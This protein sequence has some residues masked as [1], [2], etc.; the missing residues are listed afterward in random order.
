[1]NSKDKG[2][3]DQ[4]MKIL[5]AQSQ[6]EGVAYITGE[7]LAG[8][9]V[10]IQKIAS[11]GQGDV[12][13]AYN[14]SIG[15]Q[16]AVKLLHRDE[17]LSDEDWEINQRRFLQETQILEDIR[18]PNIPVVKYCKGATD[19]L[20]PYLVMEYIDG[21]SLADN[22]FNATPL[23]RRSLEWKIE[24]LRPFVEVCD[25]LAIVHS[26]DLVHRDLKP[27]NLMITKAA[28]GHEIIKVID[29]GIALDIKRS[30]HTREGI[31]VGTLGHLAPEQASGIKVDR[32]ADVYALGT[33]IFEILHTESYLEKQ[34]S[35]MESLLKACNRDY[36]AERMNL[37]S[38]EARGF[39]SLAM[40][41]DPSKR[42][43]GMYELMGALKVLIR[44]FEYM[45]SEGVTECPYLES[46][47]ILL[48]EPLKTREFYG[49]VRLLA[50]QYEYSLQSGYREVP[51]IEP[52]SAAKHSGLAHK[53][54]SRSHEY[55][56]NDTIEA[57]DSYVVHVA[58]SRGGSKLM[59][60]IVGVLVLLGG[61][62][63][64]S[65][66][67]LDRQ[68]D[69]Q[70]KP[71]TKQ[72]YTSRVIVNNNNDAEVTITPMAP[73][74]PVV[75]K[76]RAFYVERDNWCNKN[77][78]RAK[79]KGYEKMWTFHLDCHYKHLYTVAITLKKYDT[80]FRYA[81]YLHG[82]FC[83]N[84]RRKKAEPSLT[85]QCNHLFGLYKRIL[86][87]AYLNDRK[88]HKMYSKWAP[89]LRY[90]AVQRRKRRHK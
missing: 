89:F 86:D 25:A 36:F 41:L 15:R 6:Q 2:V 76:I 51:R 42:F 50:L 70:S 53:S 34:F 8:D 54:V 84:K 38:P 66:W 81:Q 3:L 31:A 65:M 12:Y 60:A 83:T 62:F 35:D 26:K 58:Q 7:P 43:G 73:S 77:D 45:H 4:D 19:E 49:A 1:M 11:C 85:G 88:T 61:G 68:T 40:A 39:M 20:P 48:S 16:V 27:D 90:W 72:T 75:Q 13:L 59:W 14:F 22:L 82:K 30:R 29:F 28:D 32:L 56:S 80:A 21:D 46:Q 9:D 44:Q 5:L 52:R 74:P 69:K 78:R 18:H 24:K 37:L 87:R 47:Q 71:R 33:V 10:L 63:G 17:E 79:N 55:P 64:L 57:D 23:Q 67:Y